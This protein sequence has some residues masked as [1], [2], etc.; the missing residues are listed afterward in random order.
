MNIRTSFLLFDLNGTLVNSND[1]H[2]EPPTDL[3]QFFHLTHAFE[4]GVCANYGLLG[5]EVSGASALL[6]TLARQFSQL[7]AI[8]TSGSSA[9]ATAWV[10]ALF[11]EQSIPLVFI[12]TFSKERLL[13]AGVTYVIEDHTCVRISSYGDDLVTF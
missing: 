12:T 13:A 8:V 10:R 2:P 6:D 9:L 3:D 7:W 5:K 4:H 1:A 11:R